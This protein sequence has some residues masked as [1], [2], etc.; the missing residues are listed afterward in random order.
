MKT[1]ATL[2]NGAQQLRIANILV[3]IDFSELSLRAIPVAKKMAQRFG[4]NVHLAHVQEYSYPAMMPGPNA[5]LLVAPLKDFEQWREASQRR[6]EQIAKEYRLTGT[7]RAEIGGA[8]FDMIDWIADDIAADLIV[9]ATH[10]RT[11]FKRAL[12]GSTA[13]RLIQH[14]PC[15]VFIVRERRGHRSRTQTIDKILVPV[16]FS[17]CSLA[18]LNYAIQFAKKWAANLVVAHVVDLGPLLMADGYG[19]YDLSAAREVAIEQAESQMREFVRRVQFGGVPFATVVTSGGPVAAICKIALAEKIDL[20]VTATHGRTGLRHVLIGSVAELTA[21]HAPCPVLVTPSH[22]ET[23]KQSLARGDKAATTRSRKKSP[24][25][26]LIPSELLTKRNRKLVR[27]PFPERRGIN[28]FRES[29]S[30]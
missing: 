3:P 22:P 25:R 10:G 17:D 24:K 13:E 28:K 21:R 8:P 14:A 4:A 19:M 15:P 7:C 2:R 5:P 16:D 9:T 23:R 6:L 20:I 29:H 11:G 1:T 30:R 12:L 18:G 26:S 27:H